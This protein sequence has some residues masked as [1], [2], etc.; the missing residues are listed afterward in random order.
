MHESLQPNHEEGDPLL[1]T[2]NT[3]GLRSFQVRYSP[4]STMA[5]KHADLSP[6]VRRYLLLLGSPKTAGYRQRSS[7]SSPGIAPMLLM[8]LLIPA[9]GSLC[10]LFVEIPFVPWSFAR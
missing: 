9:S 10:A 2:R 1:A 6:E 3:S 7:R 5:V 8:P 4:T